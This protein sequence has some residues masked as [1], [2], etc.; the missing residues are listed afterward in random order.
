MFC[1]L[2]TAASE[3][4]ISGAVHA[5]FRWPRQPSERGGNRRLKHAHWSGPS[6]CHLLGH[7][8]HAC[9]F[10]APVPP[11]WSRSPCMLASCPRIT[12]LVT[13]TMHACFMPPCHL[14]GHV[15]HVCLF[16]ARRRLFGFGQSQRLLCCA[17]WFPLESDW[18]VLSLWSEAVRVVCAFS[19]AQRGCLAKAEGP[20]A[21]SM[22]DGWLHPDIPQSLAKITCSPPN[23]PCS[24]VGV[25]DRLPTYHVRCTLTHGAVDRFP[26]SL[27]RVR[28]HRRPVGE[29]LQFLVQNLTRFGEL[30]TAASGGGGA[31][32]T[33][34]ATAVDTDELGHGEGLCSRPRSNCNQ[35][36]LCTW[37]PR[38]NCNQLT[39]CAW[40]PRS[41]CNQLTLCM[42]HRPRAHTCGFV[43]VWVSFSVGSFPCG[44]VSVWVRFRVLL[45]SVAMRATPLALLSHVCCDMHLTTKFRTV[46][47]K[48]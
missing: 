46:G 45:L 33:A 21:Q 5:L 47:Q 24:I 3:P 11:A 26:T 8:P 41:N 38:S 25:F 28:S 15:P 32:S 1:C 19:T 36:T 7:V 10:H 16:H 34:A 18:C 22:F 35:L 31:T 13:F 44:F 37:R 20:L 40:R 29:H 4:D 17:C 27:A 9:L 42:W 14:L 30:G 23:I 39:L 6:S 12:C 2:L 43:S 48:G